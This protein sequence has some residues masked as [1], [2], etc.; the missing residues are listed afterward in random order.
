MKKVI[1]FCLAC[2]LTACAHLNTPTPDQE[3]EAYSTEVRAQRN[4]GDITVVEEQERLRERYWKVYG[5]DSESVGHFAFTISLMRSVQVGDFPMT[6][7]EA[8]I[9]ARERE[10]FARKAA[11]RQ[12]ARGYEYAPE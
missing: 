10:M 4:A 2:T 1:L 8:L 6:D 7:A 12:A 5:K 11:S 3:F 9:V